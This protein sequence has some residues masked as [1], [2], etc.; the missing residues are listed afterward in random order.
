MFDTNKEGKG[1]RGVRGKEVGGGGD[2]QYTAKG[3]NHSSLEYLRIA[4][5]VLNKI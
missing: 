4:I 1:G 5:F 2:F 3:Q